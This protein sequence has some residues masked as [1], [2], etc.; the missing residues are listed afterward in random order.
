MQYVLGRTPLH[1]LPTA[2]TRD[3]RPGEQEGREH[4]YLSIEEFQRMIDNGELLEHQV[5]HGNLYGMPLK[6]V[7][8]ALDSGQANI[9]DIE[10]LG[11]TLAR[12]TYP[13]NVVSIFI[14]PPS[15]GS[16]IERMRERRE[17][18]A[19]IG[20]RLLRVPMELRY[21]QGCDYVI[22]NDNFDH[23]A[24]LL[25]KIIEAELS[26]K[27][28]S[29]AGD[30]LIPFHFEYTARIIPV[31]R[32]ESLRR[33]SAPHDLA[34]TFT[35]DIF[36]HIAALNCLHRELNVTPDE[37]ALI[38]SDKRD[39]DYLP[40]ISLEYSR[41]NDIEQ[42]AYNY[43]YCLDQRIS[44]PLGWAWTPVEALPHTLRLALTERAT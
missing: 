32:D 20:K 7:E 26:G 39:G 10:V 8:A 33:M 43:L 44:A 41:S 16:L 14:Q 15:I 9:A 37:N 24:R 42:I 18:E 40:P 38:G 2:T 19:E 4:L 36:P 28:G 11:A 29:V 25:H 34:A 31:Y 22:L 13:E 12:E 6:A 23:A 30:N 21:A 35:E 27:R 3:I 5:I 1:Q 17:N